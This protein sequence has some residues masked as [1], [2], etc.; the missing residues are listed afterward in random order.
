MRILKVL[1]GRI[2][3]FWLTPNFRTYLKENM[4]Q[5]ERRINIRSRELN[6]YLCVMIMRQKRVMSM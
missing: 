1:S 4:E 6:V 3:Y 2:G 5:L